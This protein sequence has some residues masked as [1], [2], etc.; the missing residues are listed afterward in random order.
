MA[1]ETKTTRR[2]STKK[3][4]NQF[5]G[6]PVSEAVSAASLQWNY[7]DM[8]EQGEYEIKD[9]LIGRT[10]P[11]GDDLDGKKCF[12]IVVA[13]REQPVRVM[14]MQ[15]KAWGIASEVNGE[16]I[17]TAKFIEAIMGEAYGK[18]GAILV[19]AE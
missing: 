18:P 9:C 15:A 11:K 10:K 1:N 12:E 3:V 19:S 8:L 14:P 5:P 13:D 6:I 7:S 4:E 17:V 2:N 16:I